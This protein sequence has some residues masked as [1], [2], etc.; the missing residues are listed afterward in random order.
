MP[1]A[2]PP[3]GAEQ[4]REQRGKRKSDDEAGGKEDERGEWCA[5]AVRRKR[6]HGKAGANETHAREDAQLHADGPAPLRRAH[7]RADVRGRVHDGYTRGRTFRA[8][9]R[10]PA[11]SSRSS[12]WNISSETPAAAHA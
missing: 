6:V 5:C 1:L 12:H 2:L 8:R 10:S 7:A 4:K 9:E 11:M 3:G